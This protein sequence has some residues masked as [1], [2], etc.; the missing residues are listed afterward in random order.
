VI[1]HDL[2]FEG[3]AGTPFEADSPL[4]GR[5]VSD[6]FTDIF[7]VTDPQDNNLIIEK[8]E[9]D[10]IVRKAVSS[11]A[12]ELS[13]HHGIGVSAPGQFLFDLPNYRSCFRLPKS[14]QVALN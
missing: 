2:N 5:K 11:Q 7:S 14:L 13:F 4:I 12:R 6:L 3:I 1:V 10:P 8:R 9:Y